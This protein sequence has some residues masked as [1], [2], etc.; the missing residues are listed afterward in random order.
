MKML[1]LA[2]LLAVQAK[3]NPWEP[4]PRVREYS[5]M[6][7]ASWKERH[8]RFLARAKE[9]ACDL[10]FVG[11]SITEGWGANTVWQKTYAPR[12]AVN[13]G[14][15]GDTTQN[16][17]WR[18]TNGELEGLSPKAVVLLIGTNNFGLHGDAPADVAK[19]VAAVV[20]TLR[21]KLPSAKILL[22]G[23]FPR[24]EKPGTGMRKKIAEL[25]ASLAKVE[26]VSFLDIGAKFL[27]PDGTLAKDVMPDFLHLSPKGYQIWA[28][29]IEPWISEHAKR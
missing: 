18:I 6:S 8:E 14:I 4:A 24:D 19:G 25:N 21:K 3:E 9:G 23:V 7:T 27:S 2:L 29:A 1:A 28:D 5:W 13:I 26:G 12:K 16:V 11:D 15:G 10:L 22:L 20:D 17:L